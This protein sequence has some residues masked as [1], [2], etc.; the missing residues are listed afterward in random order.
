[1]FPCLNLSLPGEC[2]GVEHSIYDRWQFAMR[3][4]DFFD[5]AFVAFDS[6]GGIITVCF[7][8]RCYSDLLYLLRGLISLYEH[9]N[10]VQTP[11]SGF[12]QGTVLFS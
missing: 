9:I 8:L 6:R 12:Y 11:Q 1:M 3:T 4:V 7:C 2:V 5:P 10:G